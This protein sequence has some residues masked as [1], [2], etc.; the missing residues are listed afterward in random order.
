MVSSLC[1]LFTP[2][3][4]T[5]GVVTH[6]CVFIIN[7]RYVQRRDT[8]RAYLVWTHLDQTNAITRPCIPP[9]LYYIIVIL[10][11]T[12]TE[13]NI[14]KLLSRCRHRDRQKIAGCHQPDAQHNVARQREKHQPF[15][16]SHFVIHQL[17][18]C[19]NS[20]DRTNAIVPECEQLGY[21]ERTKECAYSHKGRGRSFAHCAYT[22]THDIVYV[23]LRNP[24]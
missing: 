1:K 16:M 20:A 18:H 6:A 3:N 5:S 17:P 24:L 22:G 7:H 2:E 21:R 19:A 11:I 13:V 14:A 23:V 10:T 9:L 15:Y 12:G 8:R 4:K